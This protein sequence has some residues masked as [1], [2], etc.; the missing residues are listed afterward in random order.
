MK[1]LPKFGDVYCREFALGESGD[2]G[3]VLNRNGPATTPQASCNATCLRHEVGDG[4]NR[5]R[6]L[7]CRS[8]SDAEYD[9][10]R[11]GYLR[12]SE[13]GLKLSHCAEAERVSMAP[14][15][16]A[17]FNPLLDDTL[18][19]ELAEAEPGVVYVAQEKHWTTLE[20]RI[21]ALGHQDVRLGEPYRGRTFFIVTLH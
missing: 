3:A 16:G 17:R 18:A 8:R 19:K 7:R 12:M 11:S 9:L 1:A 15:A 21:N 13:K 5:E 6:G 2:M 20:H 10:P 4:G 14:V